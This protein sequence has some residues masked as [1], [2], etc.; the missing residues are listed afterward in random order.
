MLFIHY[1]TLENVLNSQYITDKNVTAVKEII[2]HVNTSNQTV[3]N[4]LL[5]FGA[6][7]GV[8]V[9]FYFGSEQAKRTQ[10]DFTEQ[11]KNTHDV[12]IKALSPDEEKLSTIKVQKS[13]R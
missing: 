13:T 7:V 9:A 11:A 6:W 10:A 3:F 5:P 12:L 8:V 1:V 4:I 2:D